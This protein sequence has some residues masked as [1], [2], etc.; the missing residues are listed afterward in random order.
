M[1]SPIE[2]ALYGATGAL[3][4]EILSIL[5]DREVELGKVSLYAGPTSAGSEVLF[6]GR[7]LI[8]RP[9]P[10]TPPPADVVVLALPPAVAEG[11]L[12]RL[13]GRCALVVGLSAAERDPTVPRV[14]PE[15]SPPTWLSASRVVSPG[16]DVVP[17]AL[18]LAPLQ[19]RWGVAGVVVTSLEAASG[20]GQAGMEALS[21]ETLS[22]YRRGEV[23]GSDAEEPV[24]EEIP[25][26]HPHQIAFN[27]IPQIGDIDAEGWT[28]A[29]LRM[30]TELPVLVGAAFPVSATA[31]RAPWFSGHA[32]AVTVDLNVAASPAEV[33]A[34]LAAAPGVE[35]VDDTLDGDYPM[36]FTA[37]GADEV[38]VGRV[39]TEP[40]RPTRLSLWVAA[41]NLRK[42]SALNLVQ[43]VEVWAA[44]RADR[45]S[46]H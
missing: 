23:G 28:S 10:A 8:V 22:L 7:M 5:E 4:R 43:I 14:V 38:R 13:E 17:L 45:M 46:T 37:I 11:V 35:V 36:P 42:C 9:V 21:R 33:R 40:G 3:G 32:F 31:V 20:A 12:A 29:E 19:Q 1:N 41:D 24:E 18:V 2:L 34:A 39:R 6:R 15:L 26:P 25:S 27:A 30:A 16:D 44:D